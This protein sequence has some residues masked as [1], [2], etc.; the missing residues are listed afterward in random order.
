MIKRDLKKINR[1][2][3]IPAIT[4]LT[5]VS[6]TTLIFAAALTDECCE[7]ES[8]VSEAYAG[9]CTE[10]VEQIQLEEP[11]IYAEQQPV[12]GGGISGER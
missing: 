10:K 2:I 3:A 8:V 1:R 12:C 9:N 6:M 4:L 5:T 11:Q 7:T